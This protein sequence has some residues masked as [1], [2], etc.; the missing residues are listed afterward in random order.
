MWVTVC[1]YMGNTRVSEAR[2]AQ[3]R[4]NLSLTEELT[5]LHRRSDIWSE[6]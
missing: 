1:P 2:D 3:E 5:V 4:E 6:P